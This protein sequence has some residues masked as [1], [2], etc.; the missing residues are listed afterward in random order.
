MAETNANG[1]IGKSEAFF[2]KS[3]I[4]AAIRFWEP[5][6]VDSRHEISAECPAIQKQIF[7]HF[8]IN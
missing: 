4:A 8:Q 3:E 7:I 6:I 5:L 2:Y 1:R